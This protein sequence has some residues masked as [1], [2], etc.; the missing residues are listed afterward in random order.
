MQVLGL[1]LEPTPG[2]AVLSLGVDSVPLSLRILISHILLAAQLNLVRHWKDQK[3]PNIQE[4]IQLIN[5]HV[6]MNYS[7]HPVWVDTQSL[8]KSGNPGQG[9]TIKCPALDLTLIFNN[10]Q[11]SLAYGT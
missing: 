9:G 4:T 10:S 3:A 2:M 5:T 7:L 6:I 11:E 1:K 8:T